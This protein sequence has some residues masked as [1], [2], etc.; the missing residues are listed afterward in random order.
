MFIAQIL[1]GA[2]AGIITPAIGA[3]SLGLVG[4][5]AMSV[6]TGRNYRYSAAG[7]A[8]RRAHGR[9][10][11]IYRQKRHLHF[12]RGALRSGAR[13]Q[14]TSLTAT[15]STMR[16]PAMP[17]VVK[18]P[19]TDNRTTSIA[20]QKVERQ[21]RRFHHT[22]PRPCKN[23]K[24][25]LF[26]AAIVIFQLADASMLPTMG[27][28][29]ATSRGPITRHL[30]VGSDHRPADRGCHLGAVGRFPFREKRPATIILIGFASNRSARLVLAA[31]AAY[32][33]LCSDKSSAA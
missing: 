1:Q 32:P 6:R 12:R 17:R 16:A 22:H 29:L 28:N 3:I 11:C 13:L 30:D 23:R 4:R 21:A 10:R 25:V 18:R 2:T 19:K 33:A 26:T 7:H 15:K 8:L 24:L 20:Q 31:S 27:E 14:S 9:G 5:S